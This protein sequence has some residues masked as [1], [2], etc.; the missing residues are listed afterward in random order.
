ML[1][2]DAVDVMPA[3]NTTIAAGRD[4]TDADLIAAGFRI[5][6][7]VT[8]TAIEDDGEDEEDMDWDSHL[9][10]IE[11]LRAERLEERRRIREEMDGRVVEEQDDETVIVNANTFTRRQP[12]AEKWTEQETEFF[13][14]VGVGK[15]PM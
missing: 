5:S 9:P 14:M 12:L 10:D 8:H 1:S 6:N 11:A 13:Y 3:E 4:E 7:D 2:D 15:C